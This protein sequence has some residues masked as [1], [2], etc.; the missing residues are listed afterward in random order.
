MNIAN[1]GKTWCQSCFLNSKNQSNS[2]NSGNQNK[3]Q[4]QNRSSNFNNHNNN[5]ARKNYSVNNNSKMNTDWSVTRV[6]FSKTDDSSDEPLL[7][8]NEKLM[9]NARCFFCTKKMNEHS[10]NEKTCKEQYEY[11]IDREIRTLL[12]KKIVPPKRN[13]RPLCQPMCP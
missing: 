4:N 5:D 7:W 3:N 12:Q 1:P 11:Y 13:Q 9:K 2:K 10:S 6:E 8:T